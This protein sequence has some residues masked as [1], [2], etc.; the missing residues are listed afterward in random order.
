MD[1]ST[2]VTA[3]LSSTFNST[4]ALPETST[5]PTRQTVAA[6]TVAAFGL[7]MFSIG[8]C[9]NS[10]VLAVLVSARRHAGMQ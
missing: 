6:H 10:V 3:G 9:A 8:G 7:V 4:A 5:S 1:N 2:E